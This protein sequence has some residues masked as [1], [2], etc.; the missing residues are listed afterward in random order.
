MVVGKQPSFTVM[1]REPDSAF[2]RSR[3]LHRWLSRVNN[4]T[5]SRTY[6]LV[7]GKINPPLHV[8]EGTRAENDSV[9]FN[10]TEKLRHSRKM[11]ENRAAQHVPTR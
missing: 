10:F 4:T 11:M 2:P 8:Y 1:L 5:F 7:I 3:S 6:I 9:Q